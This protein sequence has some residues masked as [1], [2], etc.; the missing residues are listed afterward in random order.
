MWCFE[1]DNDIK[2]CDWCNWEATVVI[3]V[4]DCTCKQAVVASIILWVD[5]INITITSILHFLM[6]WTFNIN[7][8]K[9]KMI[10]KR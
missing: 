7:N 4:A 5:T 8:W 2:D 6:S 3:T 10:K 9:D 1:E